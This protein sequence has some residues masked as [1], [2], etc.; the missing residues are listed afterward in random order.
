M[1][2]YSETKFGGPVLTASHFPSVGV[3]IRVSGTPRAVSPT[4]R[5]LPPNLDHAH[6]QVRRRGRR[7]CRPSPQPDNGDNPTV[8]RQIK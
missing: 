3:T 7:L 4:L 6:S 2:A 8:K 5:F 1:Y